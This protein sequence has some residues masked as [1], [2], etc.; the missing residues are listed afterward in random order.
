MMP[1][2]TETDTN[3][4]SDT[5]TAN[6]KFDGKHKRGMISRSTEFDNDF[7]QVYMNQPFLGVVSMEITKVADTGAPTAY[8]GARKQEKDYELTLGYNPDFF[9][10][11]TPEQ[12][13]G[14][15]IHELYH[16]IFQ[17]VTRRV[18]ADKRMN[19]LWNVAT[20]LAINSIILDKDPKW[21]P[22]FCLLPGRRP[23]RKDPKTGKVTDAGDKDLCDFIAKAPKLE[24]A[25][26][27]FEKMKEII[28]D[29]E[30]DSNDDAT[31]GLSTLD[32]HEGW[33]D[34]PQEIEEE[35]NERMRDLLER[36]VKRADNQS[37]SW[38]SI[39]MEIQEMIR[40]MISRE[41][42]WRSVVRQFVGRCRSSERVS[43]VRKICK[44]APYKLPGARR[45]THAKFR[46]FI[47]QS[48]SMSDEDISMLFGELE[49]LASET[50]IEV[51]HFDTEIDEKSATIWR[52]GKAFPKAHRT[53]CGGTIFQAI[54][55]FCNRQDQK[56]KTDGVII[57]TDGYADIMG[58]IVGAR[59]LWVITPGGTLETVRSGDLAVKMKSADHGKF[60]RK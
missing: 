16:L 6:E 27:Y 8:M 25:D 14:V 55:D 9:R 45:K 11:L 33:G 41:I 52:K 17:H 53:R 15:I 44:R 42:D 3:K 39:P 56:G 35:L 20:D 23:T 38:G 24:A 2:M 1:V 60:G 50:E 36:A 54:A 43:S 29:R 4:N 57:L 12:R 19:Q 34:I 26:Y 5:N 7:L 32:D 51:F 13:Q 22:E 21:L 47:D 59:V 31:G 30:D 58:P 48:G 49:G 18:V 28:Q 46:C 40:K 37:N 10:S